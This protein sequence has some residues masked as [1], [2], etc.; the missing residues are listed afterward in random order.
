MVKSAKCA[1]GGDEMELSER[2]QK[3][4]G[5]VVEQYIK[6]GE[7]VGSKSLLAA[8]DMA[9]SSATV[10]N[11]MA[12]LSA[13]G[14][15]E[16]PHTSAGRIPTNEGYRY[17]V[18]NLMVN[19]QID[20]SLRRR[21]QA[22]FSSALTDPEKLLERAGEV[23]AD[24]TDCAAISTTPSGEDAYI[25]R[26][27]IVPVGTRTAMVV[28]MTSTGVIKSKVCRSDTDLNASI[29]ESF[30][31]VVKASFVGKL[32][33]DVDTAMM[34]TLV[35]SLGTDVFTLLPLVT[36]VS[37]LAQEA[38]HTDVVLGGQSNL[39]HYTSYY[40]STAYE[41]LE[42]LRRGEPLSKLLSAASDGKDVDVK[43][44]SENPY[45][46]LMKSSVIVSN[47]NIDGN[48][49]GSIGIIGPTRIDYANLIPSVK[50]LTDLVGELLTQT[51]KEE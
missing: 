42:F 35:A 38:V 31:N 24:L 14:L 37:D 32:L 5:A 40:G 25:R 19:R 43:I 9:V 51:F 39:L 30:Y 11:E 45:R 27:E 6:T 15:L 18:D 34:Q 28:L 10:R 26:V 48:R 22:G 23:L 29:L 21:I 44:G 50:Y 17:Y 16:Q 49:R 36:A 33:N 20:E 2:K 47:Y 4:L 1:K 7:P 12:E 41:L 46:Q 8:L 13:L 3:I